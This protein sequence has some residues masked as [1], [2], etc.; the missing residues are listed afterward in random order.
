MRL[1]NVRG[2]VFR[3]IFDNHLTF[4]DNDNFITTGTIP[5]LLNG[6]SANLLVYIDDYGIEIVGATFDNDS[7]LVSKSVVSLNKGDVIEFVC[8]YY[9]Y[10]GTFQDNYIL[11]DPIT[12]VDQLYLADVYINNQDYVASYQIKDIYQQTYWSENMK[13]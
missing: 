5:V 4:I 12:V 3:F 11:N 2:N 7:G 13:N 9:N 6:I 1:L 8:D 10:D